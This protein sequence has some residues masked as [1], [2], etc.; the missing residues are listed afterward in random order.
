MFISHMMTSS[1]GSALTLFACGFLITH[2]RWLNVF[3]ITDAIALL[4]KILRFYVMYDSASQHPIISVEEMEKL[5]KKTKN[6]FGEK[7]RLLHVFNQMPTYMDIVLHFD[8]KQIGILS[9]LPYIETSSLS[10]IWFMIRLGNILELVKKKERI[11]KARSEVTKKS[12]APWGNIITFGPVCA[13][14]MA[15]MTLI[16]SSCFILNQ[17]HTYFITISKATEYEVYLLWLVLLDIIPTVLILP[18]PILGL[19]L[20]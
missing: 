1:I 11:Q 16:F 19:F 8:I 14:I 18:Q 12:K 9:S 10:T 5:K 15:N 20:G 17:L 6:F 13:I 2:L 3:Y 7:F 4:W